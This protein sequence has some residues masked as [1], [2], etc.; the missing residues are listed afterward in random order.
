MKKFSLIAA[1]AMFATFTFAQSFAGKNL[2]VQRN[3]AG[4]QPRGVETNLRANTARMAG[5]KPLR[6]S[7]AVEDTELITEQPEGTLYKDWYCVGTGYAPYFTSIYVFNADGDSKSFVVNDK[8]EVYLKDPLCT[9]NNGAW[10]KGYKAGGDTIKVELPQKISTQTNKDTGEKTD[11]Y[12]MR[13][14]MGKAADGTNTLLP[15]TESQTIRY[16]MRNDSLAR[17]DT[18]GVYMGI[19]D[20]DG[21]WVGYADWEN[22][23]SAMTEP[24]IKPSDESSIQKY[25]MEYETQE[26]PDVSTLKVAIEGDDIYLGGLTPYQ[27]DAWVKG[28]IV[29][30]QAVFDSKTYIGVDP[31]SSF[32]IFFNGVFHVQK[33][34]E[35]SGRYVDSLYVAD[36]FVFNIDQEAKTMSTDE[37]LC[38]NKGKNY[39]DALYEYQ[40]PS[41]SVYTPVTAAPQDPV[42]LGYQDEYDE[43]GYVKTLFSISKYS[44]D[45]DFLDPSKLYYNFYEDGRLFTFHAD[46]YVNVPR[47]GFG[48]ALT[49]IPYDFSDDY[50]FIHGSNL[51]GMYIYNNGFKT[52]SVRAF[53]LENGERY[54][55]NLITYDIETGKS[56]IDGVDRHVVDNR[57]QS[58]TYTDLSG[59]RVSQLGQG[60]YLKTTVRQDGTRETVKFVNKK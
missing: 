15:D 40:K 55:S 53:Y 14:Y 31:I 44:N 58:V 21:G 48:D 41:L 13:L 3:A 29:G 19:C 4:E 34:I 12:L 28:K 43:N 8:G 20:V 26:G 32:H 22:T 52:F 38:L 37:A 10:I 36:Q 9:Y 35:S 24:D 18:D 42:I 39:Y 17:I 45:G 47:Y 59:R 50:D 54:Y 57:V 2:L 6:V 46:T 7:K 11:Y 5:V 25:V 23:L 1:G 16:V 27:P 60:V 33:Y 30:S 49:D 56:E 51:R